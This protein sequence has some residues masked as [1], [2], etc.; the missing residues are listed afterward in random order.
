MRG[1][2]G[3]GGSGSGSEAIGAALGSGFSIEYTRS[4]R[5]KGSGSSGA[6]S[7]S[8]DGPLGL[9]R[10]DEVRC[11]SEFA[12]Y[13][14]ACQSNKPVMSAEPQDQC[15]KCA[16]RWVWLEFERADQAPKGGEAA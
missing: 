15:I 16:R 2:G 1:G 3:G 10:R 6:S 14:G 12:W 13:C 11:Q 4:R 8:S 7:G 5:R 9:V